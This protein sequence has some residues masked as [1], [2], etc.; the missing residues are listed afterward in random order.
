MSSAAA[1]PPPTHRRRRVTE[2]QKRI[3]AASQ[4][5]RCKKC[6]QLLSSAFQIDHIIPHS[7][8]FDDSYNNLVAL[9][10]NCHAL[11]TQSEMSRIYSYNKTEAQRAPYICWHCNTPVLPSQVHLCS[12]KQSCRQQT[13][14]DLITELRDTE[15]YTEND[16]TEADDYDEV[17]VSGQNLFVDD[18]DEVD[19]FRQNLM[20]F[21][22]KK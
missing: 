22:H 19:I 14:D 7:I 9:C 16:I 1:A 5:W 3:V 15:K 4:Q 18:N 20:R 11:K 13:V 17:D 12:I 10:P 6:D 8:T 21:V 2:T